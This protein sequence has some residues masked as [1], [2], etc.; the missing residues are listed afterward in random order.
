MKLYWLVLGPHLVVYNSKSLFILHFSWPGIN[1]KKNSDVGIYL[2]KQL[3]RLSIDYMEI[4]ICSSV[5]NL[6]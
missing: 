3:L 2:F 6:F 1:A 4:K 5:A